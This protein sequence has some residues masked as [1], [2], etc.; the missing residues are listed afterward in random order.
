[1]SDGDFPIPITFT[2]DAPLSNT[3]K[4]RI[5]EVSDILFL[6][7]LLTFTYVKS[8]YFILFAFIHMIFNTDIAIL[9]K[10]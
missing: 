3:E 10:S 8:N 5:L 4:S 9:P 6:Y 1:M 7:R 2:E